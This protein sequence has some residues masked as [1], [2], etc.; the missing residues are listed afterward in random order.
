VGRPFYFQLFLTGDATLAV[1][2]TT[3]GGGTTV[4]VESSGN[5]ESE[6]LSY[7]NLNIAKR[8]FEE[9]NLLLQE[10]QGIND[11]QNLGSAG[12]RLKKALTKTQFIARL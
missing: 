2:L 6:R 3:G 10:M 7:D 4:V 12:E 8:E 5:V 11:Y 9:L 1:Q